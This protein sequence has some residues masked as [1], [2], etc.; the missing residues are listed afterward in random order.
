MKVALVYINYK[1]DEL[2]NYQLGLASIAG[3]F[4]VLQMDCEIFIINNDEDIQSIVDYQPTII[5]IYTI[6]YYINMVD[7][8]SQYLKQRTGAKVILGGPYTTNYHDAI[9]QFKYIDATFIGEGEYYFIQ[10][11]RT[12]NQ[13]LPGFRWKNRQAYIKPETMNQE[14]FNNVPMSCHSYFY[15]TI[16][17]YRV[18]KYGTGFGAGHFCFSRDKRVKEPERVIAEIKSVVDNYENEDRQMG[19][20]IFDDQCF[21]QHKTWLYKLLSIWKIINKPF[22]ISTQARYIDAEMLGLLCN[23]GCRLIRLY[24]MH[25][26]IIE[27]IFKA[28]M[29][30]EVYV[31][32][33]YP[34]ESEE[35]FKATFQTNYELREL[36]SKY[37]RYY[38]PITIPFVAYKGLKYNGDMVQDSVIQKRKELL[39]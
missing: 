2:N 30:V 22:E 19:T 8:L 24:S 36:A 23:N 21:T 18:D 17:A 6:D 20:V 38:A 11:C 10:Y 26:K 13:A 9:N 12:K 39:V 4:K 37:G 29:N 5:G 28:K 15:K 33:G 14:E 16:E 31:T 34:N 7:I 35:K 3:C 32:V 25:E 27:E 1:G